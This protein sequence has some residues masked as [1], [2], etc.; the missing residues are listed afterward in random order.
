MSVRKN[1]YISDLSD[2][3]LQLQEIIEN[4]ET[5]NIPEDKKREALTRMG[6]RYNSLVNLRRD[7]IMELTQTIDVEAGEEE[8]GAAGATKQKYVPVHLRK[9]MSELNTETVS[10]RRTRRNKGSQYRIS[11]HQHAAVKL[12]NENGFHV[13]KSGQGIIKLEQSDFF[14]IDCSDIH[15]HVYNN[16]NTGQN[17]AGIRFRFRD[18][19]ELQY[20]IGDG[21]GRDGFYLVYA[22]EFGKKYEEISNGLSLPKTINALLKKLKKK[23]KH[24][25]CKK[26]ILKLGGKLTQFIQNIVDAVT[27]AAGAYQNPM[28][29]KRG[30]KRKTRKRKRKDGKKKTKKR[31]KKRKSK[32]KSR[33]KKQKRKTKKRKR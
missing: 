15:I 4:I 14:N 23:F 25:I 7:K 32:K 10:K 1:Q 21:G 20:N 5:S 29:G 19:I 6:D 12:L 11:E 13:S 27:I 30:G 26:E 8:A 33:N 24:S 22:N 16:N 2:E 18:G 17:G 31:K 28:A 3:L 9:H